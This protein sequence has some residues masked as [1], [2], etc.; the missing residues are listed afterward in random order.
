MKRRTIASFSA[1]LVFTVVNVVINASPAS[2][3]FSCAKN[4]ICLYTGNSGTGFV[5]PVSGSSYSC[6]SFARTW[7][8]HVKSIHNN[9]GHQYTVFSDGNCHGAT[10]VVYANSSGNMNWYWGTQMSSIIRR[11]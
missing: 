3:T 5:Q 7:N 9:T 8:D 6:Y 1:C 4:Y 11:T 2:A 10:D